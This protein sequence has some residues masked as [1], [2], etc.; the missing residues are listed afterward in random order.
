MG[1]TVTR[2]PERIIAFASKRFVL[3][4]AR[5]DIF[6]EVGD[7]LVIGRV[8]GIRSARVDLNV[9]RRWEKV[10]YT[11]YFP[12]T[13]RYSLPNLPW[14]QVSSINWHAQSH[15]RLPEHG[16]DA[17][18]LRYYKIRNFLELHI[19]ETIRPGRC[20]GDIVVGLAPLSWRKPD[21]VAHL[22]I[23]ALA[24]VF[25]CTKTRQDVTSLKVVVR[26]LDDPVE[27]LRVCDRKYFKAFRERLGWG[28]GMCDVWFA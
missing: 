27:L 25:S 18:A 5:G 23:E 2:R 16:S 24:G 13:F 22:M 8:R 11:S 21:V 28:D 15:D 3:D 17:G 19:L 4:I 9:P 12:A 6:D 20:T 10:S 7:A 14:K 1:P 26:S